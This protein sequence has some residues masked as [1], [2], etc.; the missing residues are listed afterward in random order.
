MCLGN[1]HLKSE[2]LCEL[3]FNLFHY[4]SIITREHTEII[5]KITKPLWVKFL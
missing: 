2:N 4:R 5:Q 1:K 3:R